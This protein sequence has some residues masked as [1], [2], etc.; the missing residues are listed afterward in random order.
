MVAKYVSIFD[1]CIRCESECQFDPK[2]KTVSEIE[3]A[4]NCDDAEDA[5]SLTDE[6]VVVNGKELREKDGVTFDY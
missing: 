1:G 3:I 2:T 5:D 4:D 6:F